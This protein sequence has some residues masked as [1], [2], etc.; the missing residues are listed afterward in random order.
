MNAVWL[1]F[2]SG[3]LVGAALYAFGHVV[4][5]AAVDALAERRQRRAYKLPLPT[6]RVIR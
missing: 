1:A 3:I 5:P 4:V 2:V 6:C